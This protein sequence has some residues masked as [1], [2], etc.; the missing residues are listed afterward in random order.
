MDNLNPSEKESSGFSLQKVQ[1]SREFMVAA[2]FLTSRFLNREAGA[3]TFRQIWRSS[4]GF[5]IRHLGDQLAHF[6]PDNSNDE[7]K[8]ISNQRWSFDKHLVV[9]ERYES[10][11]PIRE[12]AF[13]QAAFW[14]QVHDIPIG[15]MTRKVA[16]SICETIGEVSRSIG[17]VDDDG[18]HFIRVKS[19][20]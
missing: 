17:A 9:L 1:R 18:G 16:E 2:K 10:D 5:K 14:G 20:S 15:Y 6:V 12:L 19:D 13:T 8:I 4:N 3:R 7:D 11:N